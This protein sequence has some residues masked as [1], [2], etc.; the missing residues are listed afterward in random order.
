M[1]QPVNIKPLRTFEAHN[2]DNSPEETEWDTT[3]YRKPSV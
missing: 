1:I 2:G 3:Y